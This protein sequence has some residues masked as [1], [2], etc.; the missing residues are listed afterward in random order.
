[1]AG[2]ILNPGSAF[3][4]SMDV[5]PDV[6]ARAPHLIIGR[7]TGGDIEYREPQAPAR[8]SRMALAAAHPSSHQEQMSHASSLWPQGFNAHLPVSANQ[9]DAECQAPE[10]PAKNRST[11]A[12]LP[13]NADGD[14]PAMLPPRSCGQT[15]RALVPPHA[16]HTPSKV[17]KR[18]A[19]GE[20]HLERILDPALEGLR[21]GLD[22]LRN[23]HSSQLAETPS[24][25][26]GIMCSSR[27]LL[28]PKARRFPAHA[29]LDS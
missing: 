27:C 24:A 15:T 4:T 20:R 1:M 13:D 7:L 5:L 8:S 10:Y 18:L 9:P 12:P 3:S 19:L 21:K 2:K 14:D 23:G 22:S 6:D 17:Q 26:S 25:N 28:T 29:D 16:P 11:V